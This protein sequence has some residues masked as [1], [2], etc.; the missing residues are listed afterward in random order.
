MN[1]YKMCIHFLCTPTTRLMTRELIILKTFIPT[2]H[3]QLNTCLNMRL[4]LHFV[5]QM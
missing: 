1:A 3:P 5:I 4:C 2:K